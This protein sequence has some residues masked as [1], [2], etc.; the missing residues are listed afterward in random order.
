MGRVALAIC[1]HGRVAVVKSNEGRV[2]LY[3]GGDGGDARPVNQ[4]ITQNLVTPYSVGFAPNNHLVITD[5]GDKSIKVY[6]LEGEPQIV[7]EIVCHQHGGKII[8]ETKNKSSSPPCPL[9]TLTP[10]NVIVGPSPSSQLF[11]V[12]ECNIFVLTIDWCTVELL[13][14]QEL[15]SPR[16]WSFV[17]L[18][19]KQRCAKASIVHDHADNHKVGG[20]NPLAVTKAQFCAMF[21]HVT[22]RKQ[23]KINYKCL[24]R[25]SC[26]VGK[27]AMFL[28]P[29]TDYAATVVVYVRL[30][31]R[32]DR[33]IFHA[34]YGNCSESKRRNNS[35]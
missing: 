8:I 15:C 25:K 4:T 1:E 7:C 27:M 6:S 28:S 9:E 19:A 31:D 11:I 24:H 26:R 2:D 20:Q 3:G 13:D 18:E 16:D 14:Y 22:Q 33:L 35:R 34:R 23:D 5:S 12:F 30:T 29:K 17:Q 32:N 10:F 21:Y